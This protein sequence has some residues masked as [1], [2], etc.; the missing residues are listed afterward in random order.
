MLLLNVMQMLDKFEHI[1]IKL[2]EINGIAN[3]LAKQG[4]KLRLNEKIHF[5]A[6]SLILEKL[7]TRGTTTIFIR[8]TNYV[9]LCLFEVM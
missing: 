2:C 8:C 6:P 4:T 5:D 3:V 9:V 1:S 7:I